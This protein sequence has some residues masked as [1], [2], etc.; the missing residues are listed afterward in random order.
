M[1]RARAWALS[2]LLH[3]ILPALLLG[4]EWLAPQPPERARWQVV[5]TETA[6]PPRPAP[7]PDQ[8]DRPVPAE[9]APLPA[10]KMVPPVAEPAPARLPAPAVLPAP[11]PR[12]GVADGADAPEPASGSAS[13]S[14][15]T[16]DGAAAAVEAGG[17]AARVPTVAAT[18]AG[19]GATAAPSAPAQTR[20]AA[21]EERLWLA[22]LL[23]RLR[24]LRR[25][26]ASA[27]RLGQEGVVSVQILVQADGSLN[28]LILQ[29]GSGYPTL[30]RAAQELV[31]QAAEQVRA[32]MRPE[33]AARLV[34]P[35][36]YRLRD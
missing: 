21:Q 32:E 35:V 10:R 13:G 2:L 24:E 19:D 28:E 20:V 27:R 29:R 9:S 3:A 15:P 18:G 11:P 22:A 4:L 12:S 33:R 23:A 8:A 14:A 26:P 7:M 34:I 36:A 1:S 30:D 6:A 25:Y 31:R 5:L 16:A 17:S